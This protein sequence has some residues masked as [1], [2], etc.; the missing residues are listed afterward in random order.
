MSQYFDKKE[1]L[2]KLHKFYDSGKVFTSYVNDEDL[3]PLVMKLKSLKQSDIQRDYQRILK[4]IDELKEFK[5]YLVYRE[6]SFR[7][8][9]TQNLPVEVVFKDRDGFLSFIDKEREF[10]EF[11]KQYEKVVQKYK[12]LKELLTCKPK[13]ILQNVHH[14]D[15]LLDICDFFVKSP[16]PNI[17]IRELAISNIDTKFIENNRVILDI[18]L[19]HILDKNSFDAS[20]QSMSN[21][22]F[23]RKY[24]LKYQLPTVRFRILDEEMLLSNLSDISL[25]IDQF[26]SLHVAC[27]TVFIVENQI[28]TLSFPKMKNSIV[29]FGSGYS[30]GVLKNVE[31]LKSKNIYYWGDIDKDGFA[32]LSQARGYFSHITSLFMDTEV[33][34]LFRQFSVKDEKNRASTKK[35]LKNLSEEENILYERLLDGFYEEDFRLEQERIP[36]DYICE[37]LALL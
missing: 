28:T 24:G 19:S 33:I 29:I 27:N 16:K 2:L 32:I 34:E 1:I 3:F 10:E 22:G 20:V 6:F 8:I 17:Y 18:L 5:K 11:I 7:T 14:W 23:E 25:P 37:T 9:G 35:S 31:W 13:I 21:Y 26:E 12:R 15:K 36:F 30:V 4:E